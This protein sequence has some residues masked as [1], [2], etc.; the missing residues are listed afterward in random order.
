MSIE[1]RTLFLEAWRSARRTVGQYRTLRTAFAAALRRV[2]ALVKEMDR[3]FVAEEIRH[4]LDLLP[5]G[6]GLGVVETNEAVLGNCAGG[7]GRQ[8]EKAVSDF[9]QG[10]TPC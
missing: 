3:A 8:R 2:W 6:A 1:R 7:G 9:A 10:S 5:L 4:A